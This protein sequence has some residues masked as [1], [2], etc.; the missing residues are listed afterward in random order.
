MVAGVTVL[1]LLPL[2]YLLAI[3]PSAGLTASTVLLTIT[4]QPA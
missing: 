1:A 2:V 3:L 4:H